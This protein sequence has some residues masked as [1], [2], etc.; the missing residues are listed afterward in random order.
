M[1]VCP[2]CQRTYEDE[3]AFCFLD[4]ARLQDD[5]ASTPGRTLDGLYEIEELIV[6]TRTGKLYR[7]RDIVFHRRVALN[8]F[9]HELSRD[10]IEWRQHFPRSERAAFNFLHPNVV[11]LH[12]L[13]PEYLM[14]DY[15]EGQTLDEELRQRGRFTPR[16][17]FEVLEPVARALE[18]ARSFGVAFDFLTLTDILIERAG[19]NS[20]SVKLMPLIFNLRSIEDRLGAISSG[21]LNTPSAA[22]PYLAPKLRGDDA[23]HANDSD[24]VYS[25]GVIC[26]ELASG[27]KPY[28]GLT[29]QE[30]TQKQA[31]GQPAPLSELAPRMPASAARVIERAMAME[32]KS[33]PATVREFV[34]EFESALASYEG[35]VTE[36]SISMARAREQSWAK[37]RTELRTG[38]RSEP[39]SRKSESPSKDVAVTDK[40]LYTDE[41]V[42]FTV[43]Q[44]EAIAP[45]RWYTLLA[46]AH[47]SKPRPDA[48]PDE[49]EP[50]A[51]VKRLAERILA[52]Q[53]AD[54]DAVKQNSL[55]AVPHKGEIT[56][57]PEIAG[58]EFN[59]PRQSFSWQKSVHKVE[60]EML[61]SA[62]LDGQTARGR[63][64]VFLGSLILADVPLAIRVDSAASARSPGAVPTVPAS[65]APYRKIF[66][67]Y[68][69]KDRAIVEQIEHHVHAL[70]DKYLRDVTE[71]RSGQDW[72][73][74]MR[75]AIEEADMFQLFWSHNSMRSVYVRQE[76]EYAL[77]LGRP[78]FIRPTYWEEPLP[79]SPADNLPPDE[80]RKL[81]FQQLRANSDT[82][83]TTQRQA[84]SAQ[85]STQRGHPTEHAMRGSVQSYSQ[86]AG[87]V[88]CSNCAGRNVSGTVFCQHC[89][90]TLRAAEQS[91]GETAPQPYGESMPATTPQPGGAPNVLWEKQAPETSSGQSLPP[92][93]AT[94]QTRASGVAE[95]RYRLR[96]SLLSF[97][98]L[99]LGVAVGIYLLVRFL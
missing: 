82:H 13:R 7:A 5:A 98:L 53:K 11:A 54:Y 62:A 38:F 24:I 97:V 69:H 8:I 47:L 81:H 92:S 41:N 96:F 12:D 94:S 90:G 9:N 3:F 1:K 71:L 10:I 85:P 59:P 83:R 15:V 77:S 27:R 68:S 37:I 55:H 19:N 35:E 64:T 74:W 61:A 84:N 33:R 72:Q 39:Q 95:R 44:P 48:P 43:Y 66:P 40:P 34:T 18:A 17:V 16:E 52:D 78:N 21:G 93:P 22:A 51:E 28:D 76:W 36:Q 42:Q 63:L 30:I 79:E 4:G 99:L 50:S 75:E 67:S 70:G 56:F 73:R 65:A 57:V 49:P 26:Y 6:E 31:T 89:G 25:L 20:P 46:L 23:A 14:M 60:F 80:L 86:P 32:E 88:V 2:T 29:V 45:A 91:Y 58:C 87:A